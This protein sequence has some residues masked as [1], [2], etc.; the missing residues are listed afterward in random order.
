MRGV[1]ACMRNVAYK[2]SKKDFF[3]NNV[4]GELPKIFQIFRE[5]LS[6][7]WPRPKTFLPVVDKSLP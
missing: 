7:L 4:I 3:N 2:K 5:R 1:T 6:A